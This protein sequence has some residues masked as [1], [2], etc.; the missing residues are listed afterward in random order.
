MSSVS[1]LSPLFI[2]VIYI[3]RKRK[4]TFEDI[5]STIIHDAYSISIMITDFQIPIQFRKEKNYKN[6][7]IFSRKNNVVMRLSHKPI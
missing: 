3:S 5:A 2:V 6:A 4:K 1:F 7:H